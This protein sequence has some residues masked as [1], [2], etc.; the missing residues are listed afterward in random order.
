M[1][2]GSLDGQQ[3]ITLRQWSP[4]EARSGMNLNVPTGAVSNPCEMVV[5]GEGQG[6]IKVSLKDDSSVGSGAST[7]YRASRAGG[8][9]VALETS[10]EDGYVVATTSEGGVFVATSPGLGLLIGFVVLALI[11]VLILSAVITGYCIYRRRTVKSKYVGCLSCKNK[12][13]RSFQNK[14]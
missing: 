9:F 7:M 12:I 5:E 1:D 8:D 10:Y 2:A 4:E 3:S 6:T 14:V 13:K 11:I